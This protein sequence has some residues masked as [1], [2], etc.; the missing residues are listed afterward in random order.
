[1]VAHVKQKAWMQYISSKEAMTDILFYSRDMSASW[2][3]KAIT[4][5]IYLQESFS[6]RLILDMSAWQAHLVCTSNN[7]TTPSSYMQT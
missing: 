5:T 7:L 3:I 6:H 4:L 2:P 1:M